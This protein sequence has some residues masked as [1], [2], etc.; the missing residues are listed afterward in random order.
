MNALAALSPFVRAGTAVGP[1]PDR[2]GV[3]GHAI[4]DGEHPHLVDLEQRALAC[5]CSACATLFA[6]PAGSPAR[7]QLVPTRILF[8]PGL[9]LTDARW[10]E[11]GIPVRL[12]FIFRNTRLDRWIALYP[13]AAGAAEAEVAPEALEALATTTPLVRE[14]VPDVE[15]LL[16]YDR[17]TSA[18]EVFLV[19]IDVCYRLVGE[20]RRLWRGF[21]GG[22]AVWE[23]ID[24][25][26]AD[27]RGRARALAHA[28]A[29]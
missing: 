28:E 15:G 1:A 18:F 26:F 11:L 23:R 13:S 29:R 16:V 19:P 24:A 10:G 3:C 8:D 17:R 21:H 7:Y 4:E 2:C 22:D 14:M 27:I 5:A 9:Q 25:V 12:A 20:V 6:L